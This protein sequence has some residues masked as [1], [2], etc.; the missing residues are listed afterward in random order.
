VYWYFVR[1]HDE[2][3]QVR[4]TDGRGREPTAG[5]IDSQSVRTADTVPAATRGFD[6]GKKVKGRERFLVTDTQASPT[7]AETMIRWAMIS[8]M[9]RR[10]IRGRAATH[11]GPRPLTRVPS[12]WSLG[13]VWLDAVMSRG[14]HQE[15]GLS[16][17]FWSDADFEQM[18]WHDATIHGLYIQQ[19]DAVLPR[20]LLDLD[21]IV[22]WVQPLPPEK[23][24][25]FWVSPATL[26]FEDV[27]DLEGDL[28]FKAPQLRWRT[29]LSG[30]PP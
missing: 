10:L 6:V 15:S 4:Q 13:R 28:G 9:V 12:E 30:P 29:V 23:H 20:L 24:F 16:K 5:L 26:V 8:I 21:Y 17:S 27:W 1:R 19:T 22:R 14:E 25:N 3:T 2:G 7:H 18:G 11:P